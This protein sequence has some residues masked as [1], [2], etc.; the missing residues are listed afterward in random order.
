MLALVGLAAL[1]TGCPRHP[2]DDPAPDPCAELLATP[3]AMQFLER[4]GT[5]TPDTAIS[6]QSITFEAAGQPYT[7]WSW[8]IG[9]DPRPHTGQRVSL[10]FQPTESG[11]LTVQLIGTRP[12]NK[13]CTPT[14]DGVDT[15][16]R[17][18]VL[19]PYAALAQAPIY[20]RFHGYNL[21]AP[22]D[23]FTVRIFRAP[24]Q[25]TPDEE[26]YTYLRGLGRGCQSPHFT[27]QPAWRGAFFNY[28]RNDYGCLTEFG[29]GGLVTRDSIRFEYE[30]FASNTSL[31]RVARVFVGRRIR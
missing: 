23:T 7:S 30:Q 16:R 20:G 9:T 10:F 6:G 26:D 31:Q 14:D 17:T 5:P 29:K 24:R 22:A 27:A 28:G 18:L 3:L 4:T 15:V 13:A 19:M 1:T 8:R 2:P 21:D 11:R 25:P 12:P